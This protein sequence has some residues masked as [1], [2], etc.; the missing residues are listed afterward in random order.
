MNVIKASITT[1]S[2]ILMGE[3]SAVDDGSVG[4]RGW[5]G[6]VNGSKAV[7]VG[8]DRGDGEIGVIRVD[9]GMDDSARWCEYA[10]GTCDCFLLLMMIDL[11]TN[12]MPCLPSSGLKIDSSEVVS[13]EIQGIMFVPINDEQQKRGY[14]DDIAAASNER[15]GVA[16]VRMD[17]ESPPAHL[18]QLLIFFVALSSGSSRTRIDL[19]GFERREM[20][21][22]EG[23]NDISGHSEIP[24]SW[25]WVSFPSSILSAELKYR[26]VCHSEYN[27]YLRFTT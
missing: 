20:E 6:M 22:A 19:Y 21:I 5:M 15:V 11:Q 7:W 18:N 24:K 26:V 9:I 1:R 16:V 13:C 3:V 10:N 25:D 14:P 12:P 2:Y 8:V 27:E 17:S 4:Y 23:F